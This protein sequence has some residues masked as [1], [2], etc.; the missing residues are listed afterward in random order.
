MRRTVPAV[1]IL[2][3][4]APACLAAAQRYAPQAQQALLRS[5]AVAAG[6]EQLHRLAQ[7]GDAAALARL[8]DRFTAQAPAAPLENEYLLEQWLIAVRAWPPDA[9]LSA[10]VAAL[11][12]YQ[13]LALVPAAEPHGDDAWVAAFDVAS[14]ARGSQRAWVLAAHLSQARAALAAGAIGALPVDDGEALALAFVAAPAAQLQSLRP[15]SPLLP[16]Q[17]AAALA[18]RLRDA[19][20]Y[21][22]LFARAA[23][24]FVLGALRDAAA[25]LPR[26]AAMA[27]LTDAARRPQMASAATLAMAPL[28]PA[29]ADLLACLGDPQR[30]GSCAQLLAQR[31][32]AATVAAL[33]QLAGAGRDDPASRRA[34][35][36][37]LWSAAP[38]ARAFLRGYAADAAQPAALR[39]QVMQWLR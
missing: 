16:T 11:T 15:Q 28:A 9:A 8:A 22:D 36:A 20:L 10:K 25:L 4:A 19:D 38:D 14:Q 37:L 21:R 26:D 27:V 7:G 13:S 32:D 5:A 18:R 6:A 23:D 31:S 17:A 30:G 24:P 35:L 3:L 12:R 34:L 2:L 39:M 29:T 1:L 33:R